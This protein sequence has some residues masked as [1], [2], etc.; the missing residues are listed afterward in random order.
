MRKFRKVKIQNL[1]FAS[2]FVAYC[3][4]SIAG[5]APVISKQLRKQIAKELTLSVVAKA[6]E[7]YKGETVLWSGV[8]ISSVNLKEGTMI[9]VLQ[10]P[11]DTSGKPKDVDE[12]EGRFLALYPGYL[13]VAIYNGGR[14][15]TVAGEVQGKK[16]QRLGEI[17]YT[18]PL[19]FAKEVHLW[20]VEK[21]DRVYYPCP[22]WHYPRWYAPY[23]YW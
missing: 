12:S 11:A 8:I 6:P 13:D 21:E 10:K 3:L 1:F 15:V 20:P 19:I 14:K 23:W 5:C 22:Y 9:E 16:I 4:F 17:E 18:Y 7:A 2:I